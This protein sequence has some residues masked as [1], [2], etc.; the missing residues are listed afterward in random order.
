VDSPE[1][2]QN[3]LQVGLLDAR[4][5]ELLSQLSTGE[6]GDAWK[7]AKHLLGKL[8]PK[9]KGNKKAEGLLEDLDQVISHGVAESQIWSELLV[10][11]AERRKMVETD[12]RIAFRASVSLSE[13][14][15]LTLAAVVVQAARDFIRDPNDLRSFADRIEANTPGGLVAL[16]RGTNRDAG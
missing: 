14:Q 11:L 1:S 6:H 9:V 12:S 5:E 4:S 2:R 8:R 7:R 10:I 15:A 3:R 13:E 16:T